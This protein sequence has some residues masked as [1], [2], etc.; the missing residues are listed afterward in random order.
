MASFPSINCDK[1]R[2]SSRI[3]LII[4]KPV[5]SKF[6]VSWSI[7]VSPLTF[8]VFTT[9]DESTS[10]KEVGRLELSL[11]SAND[12]RS[13]TIGSSFVATISICPSTL[14]VETIRASTPRRFT[15]SSIAAA[16]SIAFTVISAICK[17]FPQ[18]Y[19][20]SCSVPPMV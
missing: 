10:A 19:S 2:S 16:L 11:A 20:S 14:R 12:L 4:S 1:A 13:T 17:P 6:V 9:L 15:I 5:F 7:I 3:F 8:L 18:S